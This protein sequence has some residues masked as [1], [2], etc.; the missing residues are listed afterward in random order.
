MMYVLDTNILIYYF[1]GIGN[2]AQNLL[3][4]P[5]RD[6]ALPAIVVYEIETGIAKSSS[7]KKRK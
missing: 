7:P 3:K 6:I 1:K 2:V 5:K 4:T